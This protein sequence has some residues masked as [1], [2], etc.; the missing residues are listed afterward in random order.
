MIKWTSHWDVPLFENYMNWFYFAIVPSKNNKNV[1]FTWEVIKRK[2]K[3]ACLF[4][5]FASEEFSGKTNIPRSV[6]I[7]FSAATPV[8]RPYYMYFVLLHYI[9]DDELFLCLIRVKKKTN[10][11]PRHW[12]KYTA[13]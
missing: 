6:E 1:G 7:S 12:H 3:Y 8:V 2:V 5:S 11:S 4:S 13:L 9:I 10:Q